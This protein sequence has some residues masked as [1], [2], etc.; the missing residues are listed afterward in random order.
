MN[1]P[2]TPGAWPGEILYVS[3]TNVGDCDGN[4]LVV[5][6]T[7]E[8]ESD[9]IETLE[10][11]GE[12]EGDVYLNEGREAIVKNALMNLDMSESERDEWI[13][14]GIIP[15]AD[16]LSVPYKGED[17]GQRDDFLDLWE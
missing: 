4:T 10:L 1:A 16:C 11:Y 6:V 9:I 13:Q 3:T 8:I 14:T 5:N 2:I 12:V 17:N 7:S 15:T